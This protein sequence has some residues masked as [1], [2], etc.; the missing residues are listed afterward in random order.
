MKERAAVFT[1][2]LQRGPDVVVQ[3][4]AALKQLASLAYFGDE[5]V[6]GAIG[7][8]GPWQKK[9]LPPASRQRWLVAVGRAA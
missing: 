5:R 8:D 3:S 4:A 2:L 7:Y 9:P 1:Q 6:W